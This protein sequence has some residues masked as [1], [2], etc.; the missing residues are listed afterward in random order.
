M[1]IALSMGNNKHC[2]TK[3]LNVAKQIRNATLIPT[4]RNKI[5]PY[6]LFDEMPQPQP[7]VQTQK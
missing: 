7:I 4:L 3:Q 1:K 5:H 2:Y 6:Q